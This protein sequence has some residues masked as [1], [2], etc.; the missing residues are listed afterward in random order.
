MEVMIMVIVDETAAMLYTRDILAL[1]FAP[2]AG[3][4]K[5]I[6]RHMA[7]VFTLH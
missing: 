6:L 5:S 3:A 4:Q 7:I 2:Y 1:F